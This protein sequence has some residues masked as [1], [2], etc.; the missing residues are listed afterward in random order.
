M[1]RPNPAPQP[2]RDFIGGLV[3]VPILNLLLIVA[4]IFI[5]WTFTLSPFILLAIGISL[6][7]FIYLVPLILNYRQK[8]RLEVVKGMLVA[9]F[10][11][12][13]LSGACAA[14]NKP[15]D[16]VW[17]NSMRNDILK[18]TGFSMFTL[19]VTAF[20]SLKPRSRPK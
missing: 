8:G 5:F 19:V 7:Q 2:F 4:S 11:T 17:S 14:I 9:A 20:Y 6:S 3:M 12:I 15:T 18:I 1:N 16:Y 13:L 10:L